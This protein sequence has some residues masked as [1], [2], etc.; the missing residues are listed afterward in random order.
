MERMAYTINIPSTKHVREADY[1]GM[2]SGKRE[3]KFEAT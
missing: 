1:V 2:V 3:N